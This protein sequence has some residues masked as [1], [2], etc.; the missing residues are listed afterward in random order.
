MGKSAALRLRD[1]REV[2]RL[3]G[4]V[5]DLRADPVAA[6]QCI[7]SGLCKLT[8]GVHGFTLDLEGMKPGM[9]L[10]SKQMVIGGHPD[11]NGL[12]YLIESQQANHFRHIDPTT[13]WAIRSSS[14]RTARLKA[15]MF[16]KRVWEMHPYFNV[17]FKPAGLG[18]LL[19]GFYRRENEGSALGVSVAR[20]RGDGQF[21]T[22]HRAIVELIIQE[23]AELRSRGLFDT[24]ATPALTGRERQVLQELLQGSSLKQAAARLGL[25]RHTVDHHVKAI[26]RKLRVN[27][28]GE[29]FA[30]CA[31]LV[32]V[33]GK[34]FDPIGR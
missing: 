22:R 34:G 27:S 19:I 24:A 7:A 29:L 5:R 14:R 21:T 32:G 12:K 31:A 16:A 10:V 17:H 13:L 4:D 28:R 8:G 3:I 11:D 9:Q 25:S 26:H 23:L 30:R 2:F 1:I 20:Q 15:E 33:H 6:R 18:D